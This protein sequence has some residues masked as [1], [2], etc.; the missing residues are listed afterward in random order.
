MTLAELLQVL[1]VASAFWFVAGLIGRNLVLGRARRSGDIARVRT[2]VETAG[3]FERFMVRPGS[4]VVVVLGLVTMWAQDLPVWE[5]GTR[6]AIVSLI[7]FASLIPLVPLVFLPRGRVFE[8]ALASAIGSQRVTPELSAAFHDPVVAAARWYELV[9]V[10][11]VIFLMV[12][13]P[14]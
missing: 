3:P 10:A 11:F 5:D 13:K 14:F 9:V 8:A 12:A 1:H 4:L 2:L 6:W 7:A